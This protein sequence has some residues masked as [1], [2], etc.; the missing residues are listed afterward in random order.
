MTVPCPFCG[1]YHWLREKVSNSSRLRPEF[2]TCCQRGHVDI[3]LLPRPP[4][5]LRHLFESDDR[6]SKNF[7]EHIRQ[8][9]MSLAFTSLGVREDRS[10][11]NRGGWVFRISGELCHLIGPLLPNDN[12][13]PSYAQLYVYDPRSALDHRM[14]RNDNLQRNTM[15]C[16]Q[17]MLSINH[18]YANC[19]QHARDILDDYPDAPEA[20]V[21]LRVLPGQ[22]S[23]VYAGPT[24]D[25][26]AVILP[27][28]GTSPERRD[29]VLR[30][31]SDTNSLARIDDG[32]PAYAPLHYV[33]LFPHGTHG[34]HED[35][36]H[37]AISDCGTLIE[38][39][40]RVSQTEFYAF[41]LHTRRGEYPTIHRGGRLF[42]QYIVDVWAS[43]DQTR[44]SYLRRNQK[45]LRATLYSGLEDWVQSD[46]SR[47]L[48]NL[49]MRTV[50]PSSYIGGPRSMQQRY[51]DAM[52]VARYFGS[53]DIFITMTTNPDW[54][55]IQ[56][57]LLPGQTS[58]DRP[59]LVAR[60]FKMKLQELLD[61]VC[62]RNVFGRVS[63][64]VYVIEFQKRGLPHSHLLLML[65]RTCRLRAPSDVDSCISAQWPNPEQHP[66][67]FD[68]IKSCMVHGPCGNANPAAPCMKDGKCSKGYPKAYEQ[69][70]SFAED[71]YPLYMRPNDRRTFP[72]K[73]PHGSTV[74]ADN[75]WI[76]PHNPYLASKF[77]CHINVESVASFKSMKYCFKYIHKGPDRA[78]IEYDLDEI[79]RY[80][81]GRYIGAPE[82]I[83]RIF[84]FSLHEQRPPVVRLQVRIRLPYLRII[85][86]CFFVRFICLR[87]TWLSF[88]LRNLWRSSQRALRLKPQLS[89]SSSKQM[90]CLE[91]KEMKHENLH[92]SNFHRN[93]C[94]TK[95]RKNGL[96]VNEAY[97]SVE[98]TTFL[99]R[100]LNVF[101]SVH[102]L[103]LFPVR[104][105]LKTFGHTKA[106]Y[107]PP[108]KMLAQPV[109]CSRTMESGVLPLMMPSTCRRYRFEHCS[110]RRNTRIKNRCLRTTST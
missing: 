76:V 77:N 30:E 37:V 7:R 42:Q 71:G 63:A 46:D 106:S 107:I 35:M 64:Y 65:D 70:T 38:T 72:V 105:R 89:L 68:T 1:A 22:Q 40:K 53:V 26:V 62:K 49:G 104:N 67:L 27:G 32:H 4:S 9:N 51:Q 12:V 100:L 101:T 45:K 43:A 96:F 69:S 90:R 103:P 15:A 88:I 3:L 48:Y 109:A 108:I 57:E 36:H 98:C 8:Y 34:W 91:R 52:A 13:P 31:R 23:T 93:S 97:L 99:P 24:S 10:V 41:R 66:S 20:V 25:E 87:N 74:D 58:Y 54:L 56:R 19:F 92:I 28:D 21:R 50:L 5:L 94:G 60:V 95:T 75:R 86:N 84:H 2:G 16:L 55:E 17:I 83:W 44:L 29:I 80:I 39:R 47:N 6:M 78:T 82:A 85:S 81:D 11:N 59:D 14:R 18:R 33:L 110:R 73:G 61:D 79:K 102:C